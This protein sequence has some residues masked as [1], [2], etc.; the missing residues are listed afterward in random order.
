[1]IAMAFVSWMG[2]APSYRLRRRG[3]MG[4]GCD[5]GGRMRSKHA[6]ILLP[7]LA[8]FAGIVGWGRY[9]ASYA[10]QLEYDCT[11]SFWKLCFRWQ[12]SGYKD[13]GD[14]FCGTPRLMKQMEKKLQWSILPWV[15]PGD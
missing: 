7:F 1:M 6:L 15:A 11:A 13:E 2:E 4:R 14:G 12:P 8:L 5:A 10:G 3:T 9:G